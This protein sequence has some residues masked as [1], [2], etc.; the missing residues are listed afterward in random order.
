M[1][2]GVSAEFIDSRGG[3]VETYIR[4][5]LSGL[6]QIESPHE[7]RPYLAFPS[8]LTRFTWPDNFKPRLVRPYSQW[9][10]IPFSLPRELIT[11]P[12]DVLHV[13]N[14]LPPIARSRTV[15]T[16]HD[17]SFEIAPRTFTLGYRTRLRALVRI[18]ACRA[19]LIITSS[20]RS[21]RDLMRLYHVPEE[22]IRVVYLAHDPALTPE[23][24]AGDDAAR[25]TLGIDGPYLLYVGRVEPKKNLE[26]LLRAYALL[27]RDGRTHRLVVCGRRSWLSDGVYKLTAELQLNDHVVFTG[28]VP[29][30]AL[31]P[32]YRGASAFVFLSQYEG[33]GLPPIEAM[34][35]GTPVISSRAGSLD[36]VL[37]D[38][39]VSVDPDRPDAVAHEIARVLDDAALRDE[40]AGRGLLRAADFDYLTTARQTLQVYEEALAKRR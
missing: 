31:P 37:G 24:A 8:A 1:R 28:Y 16:I 5:L 11:H 22:R 14:V 13:Q 9:V 2:V 27:R 6:M 40:L 15:A 21:K 35:C 19:D 26:Q 34:A 23:P 32:L 4:L 33:F 30:A 18:T 12:V 20:A 7:F 38:A 39:A 10:R 25:A 29:D 36:E 17:L 3:G